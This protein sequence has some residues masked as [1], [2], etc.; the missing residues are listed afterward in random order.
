M[1]VIIVGAGGHGAVVADIL[2]ARRRAGEDLEILGFV[3]DGLPRGSS[4]HGL[5]VLGAAAQLTSVPHDAVVIAVGDNRTRRRLFESARDAGEYILAAVHPSSVIASD[6]S[7]GDGSMICA[8]AIINLGTVIGPNVIV[9][10][11]ASLDHHNTIGAHAHVAPGVHTGGEVVV[12]EGALVGIG[13]VITPRRR[14][15]AWATVGAGA[16]VVRDVDPETVVIGVPA[17]PARRQV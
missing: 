3:D 10:T 9:N 14:I 15:G 7:I 1:K 4:A 17:A 12:G 5:P 11:A 2:H 16:V 6:A 13:S 8:G